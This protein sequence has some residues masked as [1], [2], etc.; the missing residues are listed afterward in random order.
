MGQLKFKPFNTRGNSPATKI[1]EPSQVVPDQSLSLKEILTR[2]VRHE[3]LPVGH[4]GVYGS[5]GSIDPESDNEFN[6]DIEKAKHWD[7]TEKDEFKGRLKERIQQHDAAE[8]EKAE[9]RAKLE[10]EK[11]E[12]ARQK[13]IRI[14]AR[15][16][17]N[18]KTGKAGS[19]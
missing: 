7:L 17:A 16:L 15:K 10:R 13:Q 2:F 14:E 6:I 1:N 8:K 9:K 5:E 4:A 19:I 3:Q 18:Q 11:A 12:E